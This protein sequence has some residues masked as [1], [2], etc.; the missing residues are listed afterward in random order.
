M[1]RWT[2]EQQQAIDLEGSN[3]LV[4]AGAGSG[5]TAVL[6]ERTLRKV[7][8]GVNIDQILILTFTKAAAYE[9]MLRIRDKISKAGLLEQLNRI[10]KAYITTFDSFA[11]SVVKKYHDRL[12]LA[13]NIAIVDENVISLLK[14]E[15]LDEV[16]EKFYKENSSCFEKLITDFCLRDD[17]EIKK[18]I[19]D[20]NNKL[21]L[22]YDKEIYLDNYVSKYYDTDTIKARVNE[23]ETL[24]K[25]NISKIESILRK[26]EIILDG[27]DYFKF[28]DQLEPLLNATNYDEIKNSLDIT[29]PRLPKNSGDE[30]KKLKD[31]LNKQI[32]V[33]EDM[34]IFDSTD[35]MINDYLSTKDYIVTI[36]SIIKALDEKINIYKMNKNVFEFTDIS[37]LAIRLVRDNED[38]RLELKN[39]FN[40]IMIDEYQDTSDLQE[41][42]IKLI[43]NNNVYMVGDIKQSIY[44]FRNA[45]PFIFKEKYD[46][47]AKELGGRKIDLN[48]NFRSRGEVLANINQIFDDIMDDNFGGANYQESHRMV[49]G[50]STYINEG[51][52]DQDYNFDIYNYHIEKDSI[53]KKYKTEEIEAFIIAK[54]IQDKINN[55]YQIFDKDTLILRKIRYS[56]FV[57]LMDRSSKFTL[58]KKIF[59]YMKIP[60]TILKDENIMDQNEVYLIRNILKLI[61]CLENKDYDNTF[62]YSF[63]SIARSYL[64][65]YSDEDIFHTMTN[66]LYFD[67]EII[68]KAKT[69]LEMLPKLNLKELINCIVETYDFN[70]KLI[71]IGNVQMGISVLEYFKNLSESLQDI[72][73][74]YHKFIVYLDDIISSKKEI[75]IPVSV[76]DD[77]SCKIMTIH[78]SKG[79][80]YPICYYSGLGASFNV[81][82]LKEKI[83]YDN[84]Y[85]IITPCFK[86]GYQDTF[87]KNLL[88]QKYYFEEIG[89]KIRLFYVALTRCKEKMIM[90]ASLDENSTDKDNYIVSDVI[91]EQYRS[92]LDILKSI[93]EDVDS[94]IV[95][96]QLDNIPISNDYKILNVNKLPDNL[97]TDV[98]LNVS[99]YTYEKQILTKEHF[100]KSVNSL[101]DKNT[102]N[103]M[104]FGTKIHKLFELVDFKNPEFDKLAMTDYEK[105]CI[106]KFL[107]Q[108]LLTNINSAN[109]VKEYEFYT[110]IDNE[111]KHG[112]I[113][114]ILEYDD[115]IDIIDYKLKSINDINYVK[116]LDGYRKYIENKSKKKVDIYL[117]SIIDETMEKLN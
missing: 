107:S 37:K 70:M 32:E 87:Y 17:N 48:K 100:S 61:E 115:H 67:S 114:L 78:K 12:N 76:G 108:P 98:K 56:D 113:D 18:Y 93:Y 89:E 45:N 72:G 25:S 34:C 77:N 90:I 29:L 28:Y 117:Y 88:K 5:K 39:Y 64:F 102:M 46:N 2:E 26:L 109:I 30:A 105:Q 92:F 83:L 19:L 86:N 66:N 74:D 101:I 15:V 9:M 10:D 36:I 96:I 11:L 110:N 31:T 58:Y 4:S 1:P 81:S 111:E 84:E 50:N 16:F 47:Y 41:Q 55:N 13:K 69:I 53:Y 7:K 33:I 59:E 60:L 62:K 44:R 21:D 51:K 54:D 82:E 95:D 23:Y 75:K 91:R 65:N 49:F 40:E 57:V 8:S 63:I 27:D 22:K 24:L 94:R 106:I 14:K 42:F 80:E 38:I 68:I 85:G 73:Y 97:S 104:R 43:E 103:N 71:N 35:D 116:Q 112:I 79:L 20:L 3:I 99:E 52:T 6:S